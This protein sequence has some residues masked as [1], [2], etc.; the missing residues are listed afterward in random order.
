MEI[1]TFRSDF[2]ILH[3]EYS[4]M[5]NEV[6][7][8]VGTYIELLILRSSLCS[9]NAGSNDPISNNAQP[10]LECRFAM[11]SFLLG[12]LSICFTFLRHAL[13]SCKLSDGFPSANAE[14]ILR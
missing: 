11:N 5:I 9:F 6:W 2:T 14:N 12:R 10:M 1:E 3:H 8:N 7:M 4:F 13:A